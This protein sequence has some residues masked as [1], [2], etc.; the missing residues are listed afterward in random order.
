MESYE[1]ESRYSTTSGHITTS[2]KKKTRRTK[3]NKS[4]RI[5]GGSMQKTVVS[6]LK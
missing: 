1:K 6:I 4:L 2:I 5:K 3:K